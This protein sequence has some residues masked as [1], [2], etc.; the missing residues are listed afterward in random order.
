MAALPIKKIRDLTYEA[1]L[2][3]SLKESSPFKVLVLDQ[4]ELVLKV[5]EIRLKN[6]GAQA[7]TLSNPKEIKKIIAE[8]KID[9]VILNTQVG[10]FSGQDI[11]KE[12]RNI[13]SPMQ[14]PVIM[15]DHKEKE[16][17]LINFLKL[18]ANDF[19]TMPINFTVSW[20]RI[21]TQTTIKRFYEAIEA[22][23]RETLKNASMKILLEMI[24]NIAHE[25]NNPLTLISGKLEKMRMRIGEKKDISAELDEVDKL[26]LRSDDV[27]Q[28]LLIFSKDESQSPPKPIKFE[29]LMKRVKVICS[30]SL[31]AAGID[32]KI[33]ENEKNL[34]IKGKEGELIQ[35]FF[36]LIMNAKREIAHTPN[37]FIE[38]AIEKEGTNRAK[39]LV[40][41]SGQGIPKNIKDIIFEPF[42]TTSKSEYSIGMGL[43]LSKDLVEKNGGRIYLN[44]SSKNTQFVIELPLWS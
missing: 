33:L 13:Y 15:L 41:D 9:L 24:G 18:G 36:L 8:K 2:S 28:N 1:F 32:F 10:E 20:A 31:L 23:R 4:N 37:P 22:G 29:D 14:L 16:D 44:E 5:I 27:I 34:N 38:I 6:K 42:F 39:I 35:V 17:E 25:I 7:F 26:I 19:I 11:L 43:P 30:S 21:Q 12:I 3:E 40:T